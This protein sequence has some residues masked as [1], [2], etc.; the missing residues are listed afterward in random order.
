M[1]P[2]STSQ[3]KERLGCGWVARDHRLRNHSLPSPRKELVKN[4]IPIV[5]GFA[6]GVDITA[7]LTALEN[8]GRT[9][10]VLGGGFYYTSPASHQKYV[11]MMVEKGLFVSEFTPF[12]KP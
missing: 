10:A 6:R 8:E 4:N 5:S 7:H 9:I 11:N 3:F 2:R 1:G 12:T